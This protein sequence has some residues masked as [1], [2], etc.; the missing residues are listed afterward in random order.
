MRAV[1]KCDGVM[2]E[3]LSAAG[4][5]VKSAKTSKLQFVLLWR[6]AREKE[7]EEYTHGRYFRL[8]CENHE[9]SSKTQ[10]EINKFSDKIIFA[11]NCEIPFEG[12]FAQPH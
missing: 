11:R 10:K 1:F 3:M 5:C 7:R 6:R 2:N 8:K 12:E 9:M 4:K